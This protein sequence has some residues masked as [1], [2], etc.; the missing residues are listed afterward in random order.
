MRRKVQDDDGSNLYWAM[1]PLSFMASVEK[2]F[3][4]NLNKM[5]KHLIKDGPP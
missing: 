5:Y 3:L 1:T 4:Y 2:C